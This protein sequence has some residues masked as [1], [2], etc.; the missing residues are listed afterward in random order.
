MEKTDDDQRSSLEVT[1][2]TAILILTSIL[3]LAGNSLLCLAFYRNRRLRTIANFYVLSLAVADMTMA[4]FYFPFGA[5]ASSF[6]K[7]PFTNSY[8]HFTSF[9]GV[10]WAQISTVTLALA[11]LNRYFCVVK[12]QRYST[13]FTRKKA[14]ISIVALWLFSWVL[15]PLFFAANPIYE[16]S[17][18]FL[19]CRAIFRDEQAMRISY[20]SF[21]C[22]FI[23]PM[24]LV[25]LCYS[26]IYHVIRHHNHAIVPSLQRT[27]SQ[28]TRIQDI[29]TCRVVFVAVLGFCLCWSPFI[30]TMV[31]KFGFQKLICPSVLSIC[32][33]LTSASAF[34][35]PLIYGVMNQ[36]M[37]MEFLKILLFRSG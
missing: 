9:L 35:N 4:V 16:W 23:V 31:L 32:F 2:H 25:I 33:L 15:T 30:S 1:I 26:S 8:C 29:K 20:L 6:R 7:W 19:N 36:T 11:S 12:P 28:G 37:R 17:P 14:I 34:I 10:S 13:L 24:L 5:V 21:G 3:S 18:V 27:N 22:L